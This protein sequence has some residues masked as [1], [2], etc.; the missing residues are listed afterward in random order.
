MVDAKLGIDCMEGLKKKRK[1]KGVKFRPLK[2][3][4]VE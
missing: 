4:R 2:L 3:E 1:G